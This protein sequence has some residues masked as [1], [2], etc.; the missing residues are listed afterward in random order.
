VVPR[1]HAPLAQLSAVRAVPPVQLAPVLQPG[2]GALGA[3]AQRK[4]LQTLQVPHS[5]LLQQLPSTQLVPHLRSPLR[6]TVVEQRL[7]WQANPLAQSPSLQQLPSTQL[8]PQ[9]RLPTV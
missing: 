6:H 7:L 1:W 2:A 8:P 5:S 4:P 9:L 3:L